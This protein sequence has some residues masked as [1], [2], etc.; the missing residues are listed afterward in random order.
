MRRSVGFAVLAGIAL[1]TVACERKP[2][3]L[4][5]DQAWIRLPAVREQPGAAYFTL[6]GG[7]Q[8]TTLV[9]VAAPF[10]VRTEMHESMTGEHDMATMQPLNEVALPPGGEVV[11]KPGGKHVMLFDVGPMVAAGQTV[12]LTLEFADGK[13][14]AVQARVVGAGDPPPESAEH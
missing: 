13:S 8:A 5:V 12:P 2:A 14:L 4:A 11:F 6:R 1:A 7:E 3:V 10:A 9:K